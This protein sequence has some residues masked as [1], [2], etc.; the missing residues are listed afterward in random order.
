VKSTGSPKR[1]TDYQ[2][3]SHGVTESEREGNLNEDPDGFEVHGADDR[4][5]VVDRAPPGHGCL[6]LGQ[7]GQ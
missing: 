4:M 6:E 7:L 5:G 1:R 3:I 2:L